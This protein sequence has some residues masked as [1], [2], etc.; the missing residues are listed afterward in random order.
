M[1][2]AQIGRGN[3]P[4]EIMSNENLMR[5]L[6]LLLMALDASNLSEKQLDNLVREVR[7]RSDR[8]ATSTAARHE[9]I[10]TLKRMSPVRKLELGAQLNQDARTL[11]AAGLRMLHPDWSEKR[12]SEEVRK[13][14]IYATD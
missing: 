6:H 4:R 11:K 3:I 1:L 2:Q 10:E 12:V 13:A 14:F 5:K 7:R 9:Q 8:S